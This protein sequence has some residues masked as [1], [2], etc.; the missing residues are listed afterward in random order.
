MTINQKEQRGLNIG[1]SNEVN[2]AHLR[3]SSQVQSHADGS[4]DDLF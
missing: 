2:K 1:V 3:Q 4:L